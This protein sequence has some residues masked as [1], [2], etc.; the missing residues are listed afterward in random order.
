[1]RVIHLARKPLAA[2]NVA[3][4]V[5]EHGTGALDIDGSRVE[6]GRWPGNVVLEHLKGC[7]RA[8]T[9]KVK[10]IQGTA[11][12]RMAGKGNHVYGEYAGS[13]R[14]GEKTGYGDA[15]G[16]EE[17][18]SWECEPG[19]PVADLDVQSFAGGIHSAGGARKALVEGQ[20]TSLFFGE[21]GPREMPRFGDSGGASRFYKQVGGKA[22]E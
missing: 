18:A 13:E 22:D 4:N 1:M 6:S 2:S 11:A 19:C 15:D 21:Q 8:G 16:L 5:L 20:A 3:A 14:A 17:V 10:A 9:R 12:G 7:R